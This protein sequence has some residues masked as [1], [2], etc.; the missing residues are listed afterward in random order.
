MKKQFLQN[1]FVTGLLV[2]GLICG[3]IGF[4]VYNNVISDFKQVFSERESQV[5]QLID[6][7]DTLKLEI[8]EVQLQKSKELTELEQEYQGTIAYLKEELD[9]RTPVSRGSGHSMG[10]EV[11]AYT[12]EAGALTASGHVLSGYIG[13]QV[14]AVDPDLIPLGSQV[15]ISFDNPAYEH[16]NGVYTAVDTGGAIQ[17][18]IIDLYYGDDYYGACDF[19]RQTATIRVI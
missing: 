5:Q 4:T 2:G 8:A 16:L 13:E 15:Q 6:E 10:V 7:N 14:I 11:T 1:Q 3:G 19:G 17:G 18:N 9:R 12:A